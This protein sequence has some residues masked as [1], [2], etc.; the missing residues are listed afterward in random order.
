MGISFDVG[1]DRKA[2]SQQCLDN[3]KLA[4]IG[5]LASRIVTVRQPAL[6]LQPI[7]RRSLT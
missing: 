1:K 4:D 2:R 6:S 7:R 5:E 3:Y